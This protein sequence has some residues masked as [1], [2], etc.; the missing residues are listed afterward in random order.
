MSS[1]VAH[2]LA[3]ASAEWRLK[4][5]LSAVLVPFF[6]V[7]YFLVQRLPLTSAWRLPPGRIEEAVGFHPEWV[8]VYQ[9]AYMLLALVPWLAASTAEDLQRYARGFVLLSCIG[10]TCFLLLPIEL[11]R[12]PEAPATGMYGVLV[13]YDRPVN[14]FPSLHVGLSVYTVLFGVRVLGARVSSRRRRML[15]GVLGIWVMAIA[16]AAVAIRQHFLVDLPAGA[17]LAWI[18]HRWAWKAR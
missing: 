15:I 4:V 11:P 9:S 10:F 2:P 3:L 16:F 18:C 7:P 8:W 5:L 12:P 13:S 14:T 17:L 1:A 6:C